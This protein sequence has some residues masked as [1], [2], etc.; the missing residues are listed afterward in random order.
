MLITIVD[1]SDH[2]SPEIVCCYD[3]GIV[4]EIGERW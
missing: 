4:R 2:S 1:Y 3:R